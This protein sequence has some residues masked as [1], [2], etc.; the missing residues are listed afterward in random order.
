MRNTVINASFH[1]V[2]SASASRGTLPHQYMK[3]WLDREVGESQ[4]LMMEAE[5]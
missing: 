2:E 4:K 1:H 5:M 3:R